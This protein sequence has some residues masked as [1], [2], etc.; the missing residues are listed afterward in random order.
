MAGDV[1]KPMRGGF[2]EA[3][4][5]EPRGET[6]EGDNAKRGST[7]G[8]RVT[9]AHADGPTGCINP[10]SRGTASSDDV[11]DGMKGSARRETWRLPAGEHL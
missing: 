10:W 9:L 6:L 7:G 3:R 5:R 11:G 8:H 2:V 1:L 4:G